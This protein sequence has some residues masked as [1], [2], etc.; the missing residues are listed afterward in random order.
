MFD[1]LSLR[2]GHLCCS[3][4]NTSVM[5]LEFDVKS[6]KVLLN[7]VAHA[8]FSC[9]VNYCNTLIGN[10]ADYG[11]CGLCSIQYSS[12]ALYERNRNTKFPREYWSLLT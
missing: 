8:L 10:I 9:R 1:S 7:I 3:Y 4:V 12:V 5:S 11:L 2:S 6:I